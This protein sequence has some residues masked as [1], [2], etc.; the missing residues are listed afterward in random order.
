MK[1]TKEILKNVMECYENGIP[2][3]IMNLTSKKKALM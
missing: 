2:M 1:D 3:V